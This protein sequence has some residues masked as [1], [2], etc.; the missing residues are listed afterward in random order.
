MIIKFKSAIQREANRFFKELSN[1]DFNI[2]A[3]T[4]SAFTKARA[5]LNLWALKR[6]NEVAVNTFYNK[7][8]Y[9]TWHNRRVLATDELD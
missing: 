3:V 7:A 5:K 4:K 1:E 8:P 9:H 2:R 6:L